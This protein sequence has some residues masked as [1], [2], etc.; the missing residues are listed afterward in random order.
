MKQGE[1]EANDNYLERFKSNIMTVELTGGKDFFCSKG[2][3]TK[4]NDDPTDDE[5]KAEEDKMQA[6]LLLKNA[7]E[8]QHGGSSKILKEGGFLA[9]DECPISI[10][11]IYE[12]M[13][14]YSA[15]NDNNGNN[16]SINRYERRYPIDST[17]R[18]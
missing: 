7:V 17:R 11:S 15:Q 18:R 9:R 4:D 10:A 6:I 1:T 12:L 16:G 3:M 5:I 8:K 14:K 2:I 13:V